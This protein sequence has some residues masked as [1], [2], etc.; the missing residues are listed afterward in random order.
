VPQVNDHHRPT[1]AADPA[2]A[3]AR[4][5]QDGAPIKPEPAS[6]HFE[7]AR[8][9][10][11]MAVHPRVRGEHR[12]QSSRQAMAAGS[13]PRA[14]G[15]LF[16]TLAAR[17]GNAVAELID[18]AAVPGLSGRARQA[19]AREVLAAYAKLYQERGVAGL[20]RETRPVVAA[21]F[22]AP[23]GAAAR[24]QGEDLLAAVRAAQKSGDAASQA[25]LLGQVR[26]AF[27]DAVAQV[28]AGRFGARGTKNTQMRA[29]AQRWYAGNLR[30]RTVETPALNGRPVTFPDNTTK[31]FNQVSAGKLDALPALP[32]VLEQGR[33]IVSQPDRKD[34]GTFKAVHHIGANIQVGDELRPV[35]VVVHEKTSGD[36]FYVHYT[37]D[38][39]PAPASTA[40]G[41]IEDTGVAGAKGG[42]PERPAQPPGDPVPRDEAG[43]SRPG[44]EPREGDTPDPLEPQDQFALDLGIPDGETP[45]VQLRTLDEALEEAQRSDA[46]VERFRGCVLPGLKE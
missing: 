28:E 41:P 8:D 15:T 40:V 14:R 34:R 46:L 16:L 45:S 36:L 4:F 38:E 10:S 42:G 9:W 17:R 22:D 29:E 5:V 26:E 7:Q 24:L 44:G 33:L 11:M 6:E 25:A 21:G 32:D 35:V 13:S 39:R 43:G 2:R 37:V 12:H 27:G 18:R 1:A 20:L 30:G 23:A 3:P 19:A 31:M